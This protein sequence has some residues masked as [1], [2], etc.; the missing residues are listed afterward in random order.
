MVLTGP[1]FFCGFCA[2]NFSRAVF[3][4]SPLFSIRSFDF[5]MRLPSCAAFLL[6]E[7]ECE[8]APA[9]SPPGGG[10]PSRRRRSEGR[11]FFLSCRS[12]PDF[13]SSWPEVAGSADFG[14]IAVSGAASSSN[15]NFR[16]SISGGAKPER[17]PTG[18]EAP[19]GS[20]VC[21]GVFPAISFLGEVRFFDF[22]SSWPEVAA[23][24]SG[25]NRKRP[26]LPVL[27]ILRLPDVLRAG[28][29]QIVDFTTGKTVY[30]GNSGITEEQKPF[31]GI[32]V[33]DIR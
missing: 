23:C 20:E 8:S 10:S 18:G 17:L 4:L 30:K 13:G 7:P 5:S 24:P 9:V 14:G 1:G 27:R 2:D 28:G 25:S 12:F 3:S 29:K 15:R 22:G 31:S 26:G 19:D 11:G 6:A 33:G 16:F 21:G 32:A